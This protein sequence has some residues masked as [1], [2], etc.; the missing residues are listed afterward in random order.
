MI[1]VVELAPGS[2]VQ[3][4]QCGNLISSEMAPTI[5]TPPPSGAGLQPAE[6][7]Q[8]SPTGQFENL[9]HRTRP[10][11]IE[12][13]GR[14]QLLKKLGSGSY[15]EVFR[16]YDP[17]LDQD[18]A[19][20]RPHA[21]H[22]SPE[23][24]ERFLREAQAAVQL[25]HPHIV[26]VYEANEVDGRPYIASEYTVGIDLAKLIVGERGH[27]RIIPFRQSAQLCGQIAEALHLA[28][29]AGIVHRDLKPT[30]ILVGEDGLPRVMD[31]GMVKREPQA[32]VVMTHEGQ[33][34]D[35]P[36]YMSPEQWRGGQDVDRRADLY[37]L[38]VILF[39]LLTGERPFRGEEDRR[40]LE[41]QVLND[42]APRPGTINGQVPADLETLCLKCLEKD[43]SRRFPTAADLAQELH[44]FLNGEPILS[45]FER[46][47]VPSTFNKYTLDTE[48]GRGGFGCVYRALDNEL[49]RTVALKF[50]LPK[51]S[52]DS[53]VRDLFLS[54]SRVA[55]G[56]NHPSIVR[57]LE[58]GEETNKVYI[59]YELI[60]GDNLANWLKQ[61]RPSPVEAVKLLLPVVDAISVAHRADLVHR[62][63]K[64]ANILIDKVG[65]TYV[66]D[67]GMAATDDELI[68][69][70]KR[71]FD[72]T[73]NYMAPEQLWDQG[74][75]VGE[76]TDVFALGVILYEM[77]TGRHPWLFDRRGDK[78]LFS[79][80]H[81]YR[82]LVDE[83]PPKSPRTHNP[84]VS[85]TLASVCLKAISVHPAARH[86][87]CAELGDDLRRAVGLPSF[88]QEW[89]VAHLQDV[90]AGIQPG[91]GLDSRLIGTDFLAHLA[92]AIPNYDDAIATVR[93]AGEFVRRVDPQATIVEDIHLPAATVPMLRVWAEIL[94]EACL[95]GPRMLT[96]L[97]LSLPATRMAVDAVE[98][99]ESLLA[100]LSVSA[101]QTKRVRAHFEETQNESTNG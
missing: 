95:H 40:L 2:D 23:E 82:K 33:Q 42:D 22:M 90:I 72:G 49:H 69:G 57:V 100:Q 17:N 29:E 16:A 12:N 61:H 52:N 31:F 25:K 20:K 54:E 44:R 80:V 96:A 24:V 7:P 92:H 35:S 1:D 11:P 85:A 79:Q 21:R 78:D 3:C 50:L 66:T 30:N 14:F 55:A 97:L 39:E 75:R 32:K 59:A 60:D 8:E 99:R 38:G 46:A 74:H 73:P 4:P 6:P 9:P 43:P 5:I 41:L 76:R 67:F 13:F 70:Q 10:Q 53:K 87:D 19:I 45:V 48:L 62:D 26:D 51:W 84:D 77:L 18:V 27:N 86:I 94:N 83:R 56:L 68:S 58:T 64:P 34:L 101:A 89:D 88:A 15:G 63:L 71:G 36:A 98:K 65:K 91:P 81:A 37:S 47:S 93:H 28:H